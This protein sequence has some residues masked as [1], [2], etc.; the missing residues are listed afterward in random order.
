MQVAGP[1]ANEIEIAKAN[2]TKAED[3][4]KYAQIRLAMV[5]RGFEE[6]L[7]SGRNTKIHRLKPRQERCCRGK[8]PTHIALSGTRLEDIEATERKSSNCKRTSATW[9]A[10]PHADGLQSLEWIGSHPRFN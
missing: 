2:V 4:L 9:R 7:L 5:K 10:A 1:T 3:N 6:N 8:D